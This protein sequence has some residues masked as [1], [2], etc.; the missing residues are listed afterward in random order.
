VRPEIIRR[1]YRSTAWTLITS[2]FF[3]AF[4]QINKIGPFREIRP[5]SVDPYDAIGSITV[6]GA[7]LIAV[8]SYVRA[9]RFVDNH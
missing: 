9:L 1:V 4:F 5:F 7:F 3:C 2:I 6:Q 8:L